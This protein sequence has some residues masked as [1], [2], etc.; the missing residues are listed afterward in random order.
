MHGTWLARAEGR[1]RLCFPT[2]ECLAFHPRQAKMNSYRKSPASTKS[3]HKMRTGKRTRFTPQLERLEER[4]TPAVI[5]WSGGAG[6]TNWTDPANWVGDV[7]PSAIDD[8]VIDVPGTITIAIPSGSS[9]AAQSL[10]CQENLSIQSSASLTITSSGTTSIIAGSFDSNG[11]S[12][13]VVGVGNAF[14]ASG[15]ATINGSSFSALSGASISILG[16]TSYAG[17]TMPDRRLTL[18]QS[19]RARAV[20][21]LRS[22]RRERSA[23]GTARGGPRDRRA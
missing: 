14:I 12:L 18:P 6:T 7:I 9:A 10:M 15:T 16:A 13:T 22:G 5:N 11:G 8:A 19:R 20:R 2:N 4:E 21:G 3:V 1:Y 17:R 23:P